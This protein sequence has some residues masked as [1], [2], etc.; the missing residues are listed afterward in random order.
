MPYFRAVLFLQA[1]FALGFYT[2]GLHWWWS[3]RWCEPRV[4]VTKRAAPL[5]EGMLGKVL[6]WGLMIQFAQTSE[7]WIK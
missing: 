6:D 7:T 2:E 1:F 5:K 3:E 4:I